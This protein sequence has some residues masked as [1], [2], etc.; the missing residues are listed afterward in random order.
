MKSY[1]ILKSFPG[2]QT[3][4]GETV[5]FLEGHTVP[6]SDSLAEV[7]LK[8]GWVELA[9]APATD[10]AGRETKVTA[11]EETKPAKPLSKMSKAELVAHAL[12]LG[13]ELAPDS[14]NAKQMV[15]AIEEKMKA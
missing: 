11:P 3:G 5:T 2:N 12:G 1:K 14:M 15:A 8:E 4:Y 10:A 7:A 9:D 13:I 6:L